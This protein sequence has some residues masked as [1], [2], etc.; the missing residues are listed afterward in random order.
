MSRL[1]LTSELWG[2]LNEARPTRHDARPLVEVSAIPVD[3]R[4]SKQSKERSGL[5]TTALLLD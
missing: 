3:L 2:G 5:R 1:L 4:R